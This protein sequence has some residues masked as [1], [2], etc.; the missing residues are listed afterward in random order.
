MVSQLYSWDRSEDLD[1]VCADPVLRV[2]TFMSYV[3]REIR[4]YMNKMC[5]TI[6]KIIMNN[7]FICSLSYHNS[8]NKVLCVGHSAMLV[9]AM[10]S[11]GNSKSPLRH[12][13]VEVN[14]WTMKQ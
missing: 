7:N 4:L 1:N 9:L 13:S 5:K 3:G 8:I 6:V 2:Y 10:E 11:Q 14:V 12:P